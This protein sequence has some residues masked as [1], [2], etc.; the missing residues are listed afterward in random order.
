MTSWAATPSSARVQAQPR[1]GSRI[2]WISS[3]TAT[4]NCVFTGTISTVQAT[5]ADGVWRRQKK[6]IEGHKNTIR[7]YP[8]T[9]K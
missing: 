5:C 3:M 7:G 2:I 9:H 4:S 6:T 1:I 8:I